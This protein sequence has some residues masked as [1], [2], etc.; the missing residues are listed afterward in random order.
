MSKVNQKYFKQLDIFSSSSVNFNY[1]LQL[2]CAFMIFLSSIKT[3]SLELLYDSVG[4][5]ILMSTQ[6]PLLS[7]DP[8][9]D[10]KP[11]IR[12]TLL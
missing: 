3:Q 10:F 4:V 6:L 5:I 2:A 11:S 8:F 1:L 9:A 12:S 7:E